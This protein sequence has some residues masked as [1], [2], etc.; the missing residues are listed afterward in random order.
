MKLMFKNMS[1]SY[2]SATSAALLCV[3][4]FSAC[5]LGTE[6]GNGAKDDGKSK[7]GTQANSE[8]N[9]DGAGGAE[10][11]ESTSVESD[12]IK[13]E[14]DSASV[15]VNYG[16]DMAILF[17]SCGSPFETFYKMPFVLSGTAKSGVKEKLKGNFDATL[18]TVVISDTKD[19]VL[20]HIKDDTT[21]GDHIVLVS[22]KDGSA[23]PSAYVCSEINETDD[24]GAFTYSVILTAVDSEGNTDES[25]PESTLSWIVDK[26]Q[27]TPELTSISVTSEEVELLKLESESE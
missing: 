5:G 16:I 12:P 3:Y 22:K 19:K 6:V 13:Q 23:F 4:M 2:A 9:G 11:E 18:N 14:G 20:A 1:Q 15:A 21:V 26:T 27:S 10:N 8:D 25:K 7:K 17:N 24:S